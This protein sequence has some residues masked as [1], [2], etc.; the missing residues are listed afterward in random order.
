MPTLATSD[1]QP[2]Q[3]LQDFEIQ[4]HHHATLDQGSAALI[5]EIRFPEEPP[6]KES[7]GF[8]GSAASPRP[9]PP[10][11]HATSRSPGAVDADRDNIAGKLNRAELSRLLEGKRALRRALLR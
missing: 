8:Y 9:H 10:S 2:D 3:M 4:R 5:P 11:R 1:E 7:T 6:V